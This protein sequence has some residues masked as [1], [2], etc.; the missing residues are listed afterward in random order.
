[1]EALFHKNIV[2]YGKHSAFIKELVSKPDASLKNGLF[3]RAVDVLVAASI[4][5]KLYNR[6]AE[7][8]AKKNNKGEEQ[9]TTMFMEQVMSVQPELLVNYRLVLL[10][11]LHSKR[12]NY[13]YSPAWC[14]P[15]DGL[16]ID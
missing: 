8:D 16:F 11:Q 9:K 12:L 7:P 14:Q 10:P 15:Q 4:V 5:G 1:M 2:I 3:D 13:P 6:K